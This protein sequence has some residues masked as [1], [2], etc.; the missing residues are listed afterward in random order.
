MPTIE[1]Y[2]ADL[3]LLTSQGGTDEDIAALKDEYRSQ[4]I[5]I[6]DNT[7]KKKPVPETDAPVQGSQASTSK[8]SGDSSNTPALTDLSALNLEPITATTGTVGSTIDQEV[9]ATQEIE[10]EPTQKQTVEAFNTEISDYSTNFNENLLKNEE[11]ITLQNDAIG[12]AKNDITEFAQEAA[13]KYG[14][15][16]PEYTK[17]VEDEFQ[18]LYEANMKELGVDDLAERLFEEGYED[19]RGKYGD[20]LTPEYARGDGATAKALRGLHRFLSTTLPKQAVNVLRLFNNNNLQRNTTELNDLESCLEDGSCSLDD[21]ITIQSGVSTGSPIS[22]STSYTTTRKARIDAL[23]TVINKE[24]DTELAAQGATEQL[25]TA[26]DLIPQAYNLEDGVGFDDVPGLLGESAGY[27]AIMLVPGGV[28]ATSLLAAGGTYADNLDA[29]IQQKC[30]NDPACSVPTADM[31]LDA[32]ESGQDGQFLALATG[33]IVGVLEKAGFD[34]MG[35]AFFKPEVIKHLLRGQIRKALRGAGG[36][37]AQGYVGEAVTE[38]IQTLTEQLSKGIAL[39]DIRGQI[40]VD[41]IKLSAQAG[42]ISGGTVSGVGVTTTVA[43]TAVK[44]KTPQLQVGNVDYNTLDNLNLTDEKGG[45]KPVTQAVQETVAT[46][47]KIKKVMDVSPKAFQATHEY[48]MNELR[49]QALLAPESEQQEILDSAEKELDLAEAYYTI[50]QPQFQHIKGKANQEAGSLLYERARLSRQAASKTGLDTSSKERIKVIDEKLSLIESRAKRGYKSTTLEKLRGIVGPKRSVGAARATTAPQRIIDRI[51]SVLQ[52]GVNVE[53]FINSGRLGETLQGL[54]LTP[55]EQQKAE[56]LVSSQLE[57]MGKEGYTRLGDYTKAQD[58]R[59]AQY[60]VGTTAEAIKA[61]DIKEVEGT[62]FTPVKENIGTTISKLSNFENQ[63]GELLGRSLEQ[64]AK[65]ERLAQATSPKIANQEWAESRIRKQASQAKKKIGNLSGTEAATKRNEAT[66]R[67]LRDFV[68][69]KNTIDSLVQQFV[70]ENIKGK[71]GGWDQLIE[72][73][74]ELDADIELD[75]KAKNKQLRAVQAEMANLYNLGLN[76]IEHAI[77]SSVT[78]NNYPPYFVIDPASGIGYFNLNFQNKFG[79]DTIYDIFPENGEGIFNRMTISEWGDFMNKYNLYEGKPTD[80]NKKKVEDFANKMFNKYKNDLNTKTHLDIRAERSKA[81]KALKVAQGVKSIK[82][83][84]TISE[85]HN[86]IAKE[87]TDD[88]SRNTIGVEKFYRDFPISATSGSYDGTARFDKAYEYAKENGIN[89]SNLSDADILSLKHAGHFE[90]Y[91]EVILEQVL[92]R[93]GSITVEIDAL[94]KLIDWGLDFDSITKITAADRNVDK[95]TYDFWR[96]DSNGREYVIAYRGLAIDESNKIY[97]PAKGESFSLDRD[98]ALEMG[99]FHLDPTSTVRILGA[100]LYKDQILGETLFA[101]ELE[102]IANT[103]VNDYV[104]MDRSGNILESITPTASAPI[105]TSNDAKWETVSKDL[106]TAYEG[107]LLYMMVVQNKWQGYEDVDALL[108]EYVTSTDKY[109]AQDFI[110]KASQIDFNI[111]EGASASQAK[112]ELIQ[113]LTTEQLTE[114]AGVDI[115][116]ENSQTQDIKRTKQHIKYLEALID[117]NL[118]SIRGADTRVKLA[119]ANALLEKQ[120]TLW[121]ASLTLPSVDTTVVPDLTSFGDNIAITYASQIMS[122]EQIGIN[123]EVIDSIDLDEVP[124][125]LTK[126]QLTE[127]VVIFEN[128]SKELNDLLNQQAKFSS[129]VR[130]IGATKDI[131]TPLTGKDKA[132]IETITDKSNQ[133]NNRKEWLRDVQV[134]MAKLIAGVELGKIEVDGLESSLKD[135]YVATQD[136]VTN[137]TKATAKFQTALDGYLAKIADIDAKAEAKKAEYEAATDPLVKQKLEFDYLALLNEK[138]ETMMYANAA[139]SLINLPGRIKDIDNTKKY[140][141]IQQSLTKK[142][143]KVLESSKQAQEE[144][145]EEMGNIIRRGRLGL[146]EKHLAKVLSDMPIDAIETSIAY[147]IRQ[148]DEDGYPTATSF[149]AGIRS[150]LPFKLDKNLSE[151]E[152]NSIR[153]HAGYYVM[154]ILEDAGVINLIEPLKIKESW[155][156]EIAKEKADFVVD[157]VQGVDLANA[158]G[159]IAHKIE[160]DQAT[161]T[162]LSKKKMTDWKSHIHESGLKAEGKKKPAEYL[163]LKDNPEAFKVLNTYKNQGKRINQEAV[164]ANDLLIHIGNAQLNAN[165]KNYTRSEKA[166]KL[167]ERN[168]IQQLA[169]EVGEDVVYSNAKFGSRFRFYDSAAYLNHQA[170]KQ[171]QSYIGS[172]KPEVLTI[173]GYAWFLADLAE[174]YGAKVNELQELVAFADEK[175]PEFLTWA[176]NLSKHQYDIWTNEKGEGGVDA[177]PLFQAGLIELKNMLQHGDPT[178]YPSNYI[179]YIDDSASGYQH[180]GGITK[181]LALMKDVNLAPNYR[182]QDPY[183][184][185]VEPIIAEKGILNPTEEQLQYF[186]T[187]RSKLQEFEAQK[188]AAIG[189]DKKYTIQN[190]EFGKDP[191]APETIQVS[192]RFFINKQKELYKQTIDEDLFNGVFWGQE[193]WI[194]KLRK[195]GKDGL[196]KGLYGARNQGLASGLYNEFKA[197]KNKGNEIV[198]ENTSWLIRQIKAAIKQNYPIV[199]ELE[200]FIKTIQEEKIEAVLTAETAEEKAAAMDN[201]DF[202]YSGKFN[203]PSKPTYRE[204]NTIRVNYT[205]TKNDIQFEF[206]VGDKNDIDQKAINKIKGATFVNMIHTMDKE[207]PIWLFLNMDKYDIK[208]F[209][210]VHDAYG[211]T[212]AKL[213]KLYQAVRDARVDIYSDDVLY[214]ILKENID[215]PRARAHANRLTVGDWKPEMTYHNQHS[216]SKSGKA[217]TQAIV[218]SLKEKAGITSTEDKSVQADSTGGEIRVK[219]GNITVTQSPAMQKKLERISKGNLKHS[220]IGN[221]EDTSS[222]AVANLFSIAESIGNMSTADSVAR[223]VDSL[224]QA[225]LEGDVDTYNRLL[226]ELDT[227]TEDLR[228]RKRSNNK[229]FKANLNNLI[230]LYNLYQLEVQTEQAIKSLDDFDLNIESL[231]ETQE[232]N[233][234]MEP[235]HLPEFERNKGKDSSI[236]KN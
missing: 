23:K 232:E 10:V 119:E 206:A 36:T 123:K 186:N 70:N 35:K 100:K 51:D 129:S 211:T 11:F 202:K 204:P 171:A 20:I 122:G 97:N 167:L 81:N 80:S 30:D 218:S 133:L 124:D 148:V 224:N 226:E 140:G 159:K 22:A 103:E 118:T 69:I 47:S 134:N 125:T 116:L 154:S 156:I 121:K 49:T 96:K 16:T 177:P 101:K 198:P 136:Y 58:R 65:N 45:A 155:G 138:S 229:F 18:R 39:G 217:D 147:A 115:T 12:I 1:Q 141:P 144:A 64:E 213:P 161:W 44:P 173:E 230:R 19:I 50:N 212:L 43:A 61:T 227:S 216:T 223:L 77:N 145:R 208:A 152:K 190:P 135:L 235:K 197:D 13:N 42:G 29:I 56:E 48:K 219:D 233:L 102:V 14:Y 174:N 191:D 93:F 195:A 83:G 117:N 137:P 73:A 189:S 166:G 188:E 170:S 158:T 24:I 68:D 132:D 99:E 225:A 231:E 91:A 9:V 53:E 203:L 172:E 150:T 126:D 180:V 209:F 131:D 82:V 6:D 194:G 32:I 109:S 110:T 95:F 221:L 210:P 4:G 175:L 2:N 38:A 130:I 151:E 139:K 40:N 185:N 108:A 59:R 79:S 57:K 199:G 169:K 142:E 66:I 112:L 86:E 72:K 214:N 25:N 37:V 179:S 28:V 54:G 3:E 107:E 105:D 196:M 63:K 193:Y 98:L 165:D 162:K 234:D 183:V 146:T 184:K 168:S 178:T 111:S 15:G 71:E 220:T 41:E 207:I 62:Q 104:V 33:T 128:T 8:S 143:Q 17:A 60:E 94:N 114:G 176:N 76:E 120:E 127:A 222:A 113:Q 74:L 26:A 187:V 85:S 200:S 67:A 182:K 75:S 164:N 87:F 21:E 201:L 34:E 5:E 160:L 228:S 192:E 46:P 92:H 55:T 236:C 78:D 205:S 106:K 84:K 149:A 88:Y 181:S 157:F 163:T 89:Y 27:M 7:G 90:G 52:S 153:A 31:Y 215:E